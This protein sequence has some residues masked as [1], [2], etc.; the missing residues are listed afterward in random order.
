MWII[1]TIFSL[2]G[3]ILYLNNIHFLLYIGAILVVID[4]FLNIKYGKQNNYFTLI[5]AILLGFMYSLRTSSPIL[6]TICLYVCCGDLIEGI[7]GIILLLF[8]MIINYQN[9]RIICPHCNSKNNPKKERCY[10]CG[11]KLYDEQNTDYNDGTKTYIKDIQVQSNEI[12]N[13][14]DNSKL[15]YLLDVLKREIN[16]KDVDD[17][18]NQLYKFYVEQGIDIP[19]DWISYSKSC[20][21]NQKLEVLLNILQTGMGTNNVDDTIKELEKFYDEQHDSINQEKSFCNN[22]K[23]Q[24]LYFR[25]FFE[26]LLNG[27]MEIEN[28][29]QQCINENF[30]YN[31]IESKYNHLKSIAEDYTTQLHNESQTYLI[32]KLINSTK[33]YLDL[34]DKSIFL[35]SLLIKKAA[36]IN[37]SINEYTNAL[38]DMFNSRKEL[39]KFIEKI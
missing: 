3:I 10:M 26:V 6:I 12:E 34:I 33:L 37:I 30:D 9:K 39:E 5:L 36:G 16:V 31:I 1:S 19:S 20:D 24:D 25:Y 11:K 38:N 14:L 35:N 22:D 29:N 28:Y 15:Y 2:I 23:Q 4:N 8:A 18:I 7:L 21:E 27:Y 32:I 17:A 13:N